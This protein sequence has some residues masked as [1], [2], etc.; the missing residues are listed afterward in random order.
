MLEPD[1]SDSASQDNA[2]EFLIRGGRSLDHAMTMFT[3]TR[4]L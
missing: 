4:A 1:S 3:Q 2:L